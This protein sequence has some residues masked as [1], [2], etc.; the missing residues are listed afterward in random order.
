MF[1]LAYFRIFWISYS[2]ITII[3]QKAFISFQQNFLVFGHFCL[4]QKKLP[5]S[6]PHRD[7]ILFD[8]QKM[9][10]RLD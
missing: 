1:I 4:C 5:Q 9:H 2:E 6:Y 10:C 7:D 8:F 3:Q